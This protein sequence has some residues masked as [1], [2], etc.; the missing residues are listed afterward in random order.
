MEIKHTAQKSFYEALSLIDIKTI[1]YRNRGD[2]TNEKFHENGI[3]K[4]RYYDSNN[5]IRM[6]WY[7]GYIPRDYELFEQKLTE[8]YECF[9]E[10]IQ[11]NIYNPNLS[12]K[13]YLKDLKGALEIIRTEL[14][15]KYLENQNSTIGSDAHLEVIK[16]DSIKMFFD[17]Q[18]RVLEYTVVK[19]EE[20][21][22]TFDD[23][24]EK[25][26]HPELNTARPLNSRS[27]SLPKL[28]VDALMSNEKQAGFNEHENKPSVP[29]IDI[30]KI[31]NKFNN[32]MPI[33]IA[34]NHFKV[35]MEK[36]SKSDDQPF[37][38]P[39]QFNLFIQR[40]FGCNTSIPQQTINYGNTEKM[41]IVKRFVEFYDLSTKKRIYEDTGQCLEK[42][43]KLLTDNFKNWNYDTVAN[44]ISKARNV[45]RSWT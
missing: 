19:L 34:I 10:E 31:E 29:E 13:R 2:G 9:L 5:V 44:N 25:E 21:L 36:K 33:D 42:Y 45:A 16:S 23:E 1:Q 30:Y 26:N 32:K 4:I 11:N 17:Y 27:N 39:E 3:I 12:P 14:Q 37:L 43:I 20:R 28:K 22:K 7:N 38:T 8:L 40:A 18:M 35:F 6:P 15:R 41:F 24:P